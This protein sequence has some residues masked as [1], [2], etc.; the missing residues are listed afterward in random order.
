MELPSL[1]EEVKE[2]C[3]ICKSVAPVPKEFFEQTT[4][5]SGSLGSCWAG[6]VI[7]GDRQFIFIAREKLSSFTVTIIIPNE[8]HE[9]LREAIIVTTAELVPE[10]GLSMQV[11]NATGLV[12]LVGDAELERFNIK[13]ET[14][15]KHNKDSNP[16]AEKAVKEFRDQKLKF[17]P[18]GGPV[19]DLERATITSSLNK[20]LRNRNLSAR[21]IITKR[22]QN[23]QE[24]L[25]VCDDNLA[26]E[27]LEIRKKNHPSSEKSKVKGGTKALPAVVWP[28]ALVNLK[29]D[30]L[31]LRARE[32]YIVIKIE[33]EF[34]YLKK[35][36]NQVLAENHKVKLTE[37][38]LLPG[39][40]DS[41]DADDELEDNPLEE[42][43]ISAKNSVDSPN[44]NSVEIP[45]KEV[46]EEQP[47]NNLN[48]EPKKSGKYNTRKQT[49][50]NYKLL[51]EGNFI[52]KVEVMKN[53]DTKKLSYA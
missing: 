40:K 35:L 32:T 33:G 20:M 16:I 39:Q 5:K 36:K 10:N 37:I 3:Q 31:K 29:K 41:N 53:I 7:S 15:R 42:R 22:N 27:Q 14:G 30:K 26:E 24:P 13:L 2:N 18:A 50:I 48:T 45:L 52:G 23:T 34:C 4:S 28:G 44:D 8:K 12:K 21:E 43:K 9:T 11:D 19:T 25:N 17:K 6:D 47:K 51:N 46:D 1:L 38:S 49:R